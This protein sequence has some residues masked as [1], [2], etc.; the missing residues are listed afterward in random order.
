MKIY[1]ILHN[2]LDLLDI[3][4]QIFFQ[5]YFYQGPVAACDEAADGGR[6]PRHA[7][8][9]PARDPDPREAEGGPAP[10]GQA[11]PRGGVAQGR[12]LQ[13]ENRVQIYGGCLKEEEINCRLHE[14]TIFATVF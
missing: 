11:R 2:I 10:P 7:G 13:P 5:K 9:L 8:Q 6:D 1:R 4:P 14:K 12:Q 3:I